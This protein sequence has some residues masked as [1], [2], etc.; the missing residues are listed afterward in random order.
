MVPQMLTL[1][2]NYAADRFA[3]AIKIYRRQNNAK[4]MRTSNYRLNK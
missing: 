1:H 3:F 2:Y 4:I